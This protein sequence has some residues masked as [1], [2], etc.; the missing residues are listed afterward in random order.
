MGLAMYAS[1]HDSHRQTVILLKMCIDF[2]AVKVVHFSSD[3]YEPSLT[4]KVAL[5]NCWHVLFCDI[6]VVRTIPTMNV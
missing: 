4:L 6:L 1:T 2:G 5:N 3:K